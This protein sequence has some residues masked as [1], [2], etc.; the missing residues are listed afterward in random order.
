M[1]RLKRWFVW[2][3]LVFI[4]LGAIFMVVGARTDPGAKT[5]DGYSLKWFW[6]VMGAWFTGL[7]VLVYGGIFY[8][9]RRNTAGVE[10]LAASGLR[11]SATILSSGATGSELNNMPRVEMELEV[12]LHGMPPYR[13]THREFVNPVNLAALQ[14]GN[15]L[16]VVVDP[17]RRR[18]MMIVWGRDPEAF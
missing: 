18:K 6:Y 11:G 9:V 4:I 12:R 8:W 1:W 2:T 16:A 5:D 14:R 10:R 7:T 15:E 17:H 13:T 3:A